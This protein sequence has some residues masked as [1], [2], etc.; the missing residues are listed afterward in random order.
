[1]KIKIL[2]LM[3]KT[4]NQIKM[5]EASL[6][7]LQMFP[8]INEHETL[9]EHIRVASENGVGVTYYRVGLSNL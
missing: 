5:E 1:M 6:K 2:V 3:E 9:L 4:L 8:N 7:S